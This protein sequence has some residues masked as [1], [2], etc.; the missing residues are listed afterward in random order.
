MEQS[1]SSRRSCLKPTSGFISQPPPTL[2]RN[3]LVIGAMV[4]L[5]LSLMISSAWALSS[6]ELLDL[7]V[8]EKVITPEKAEKI[9]RKARKIDA[10]KKAE[11]DRRRARELQRIKQEAK[12][13]G[14]LRGE[15]VPAK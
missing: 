11:A 5:A 15:I 10:V 7:M 3:W 2:R 4:T 13:E 1:T 12:A 6:A 8:D 14:D 9:K